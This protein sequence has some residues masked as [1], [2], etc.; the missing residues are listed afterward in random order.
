MSVSPEGE[1]AVEIMMDVVSE[2]AMVMVM[3]AKMEKMAVVTGMDIVQATGLGMEM[4]MEM[5]M[6]MGDGTCDNHLLSALARM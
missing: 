4:G 6:E 5:E 3:V 2:M 1:M